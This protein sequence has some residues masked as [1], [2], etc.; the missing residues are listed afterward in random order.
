MTLRRATLAGPSSRSQWAFTLIELLVTSGIGAVVMAAV[1]TTWMFGSRSFVAM[2]NYADLDQKS[3]N[4][5]DTMTRDLRQ[6]KGVSYYSTNLLTCSNIDGTIF[7]YGWNP[8][9]HEVFKTQDGQTKVLLTGCTYLSYQIFFRN[10]T[11]MFWFPYPA[12]SQ[13]SLA[14][15]IRVDWRCSRTVLN[16]YNT[17]SVQTAKIVLRN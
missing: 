2:G 14:K 11:N 5:L 3:R 7:T 9:T 16:Q 1:M 4:T 12:D 13:P 17:E 6:C 8:A 15:L 10:P